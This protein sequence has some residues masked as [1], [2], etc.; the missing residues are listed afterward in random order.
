[1]REFM[2]E[3]KRMREEKVSPT[4]LENAKRAIV[5]QFALQLENPQGLLTNIVTRKLYNLPADYWDTY[6]QKVE[7]ITAEDVQRVARKYI[8]LQ[9]LQVVAVTDASKAREALAKYGTV[10]EFDAEGKPTQASKNQ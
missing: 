7:A 8:D 6:P 10:Q 9:H 5:G 1:M 4:E 3:F 2:N